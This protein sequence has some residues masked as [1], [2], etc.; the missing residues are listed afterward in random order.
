M[1]D[2]GNI[3]LM[4]GFTRQRMDGNMDYGAFPNQPSQPIPP[5]AYP[6]ILFIAYSNFC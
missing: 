4:S 6:G 5:T 1:G 3:P 2:K